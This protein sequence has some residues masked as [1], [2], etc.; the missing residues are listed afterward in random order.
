MAA[1]R[2]S[3]FSSAIINLEHGYE[4]LLSQMKQGLPTLPDVSVRS[5]RMRAAHPIRTVVSML[6]ARP[7]QIH[8]KDITYAVEVPTV[9]H[10]IPNV[11]KELIHCAVGCGRAL[12]CQKRDTRTLTV[13]NRVTGAIRP[14]TMTLVLAPPGHG[15]SALLQVMAGS[16]DDSLIDGQVCGLTA[17]HGVISPAPEWQEAAISRQFA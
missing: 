4:E 5:A 8:Y 13:L 12:T 3:K 1:A 14:G 15:K 7:P 6:S 17:C 16:I 11:G 10:D 2:L 9:S